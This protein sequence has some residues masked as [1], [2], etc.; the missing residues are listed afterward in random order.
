MISAAAA[1][2][3]SRRV[4]RT[5]DSSGAV[6]RSAS[7]FASSPPASAAT[8]SSWRRLSTYGVKSMASLWHHFGATAIVWW[9]IRVNLVRIARSSGGWPAIRF[10]AGWHTRKGESC[11]IEP[12][13]PHR[14]LD[15]RGVLGVVIVV[16]GGGR[17]GRTIAVPAWDTA[18]FP[19]VDAS[20]LTSDQGRVLEL[21][22]S[23]HEQDR[24]GTFYS[25]GIDEEWCADF[26]S[27]IM[28]EAG[29]PLSNP[30]SGSWRIPGVY[31]LQEYYQGI[32]AYA[33]NGS[34]YTP[35]NVGD[36]VIYDSS[37]WVGQHTNIVVA[38]DGNSAVT[39]GGNE[40]G[41]V[42]VHDLDWQSD[43]ASW[44]SENFTPPDRC[45]SESRR[46]T[47]PTHVPRRLRR[48]AACSC[49]FARSPAHL[50]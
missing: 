42:R 34:G 39:V 13:T 48:C 1:D 46:T 40:F 33:E 24:P 26:V 50:S 41:K 8:A 23:E 21:L 7:A 44:D 22:Q 17:R 37:R 4:S 38:V 18:E 9:H 11:R 2:N 20:A 35:P 27:W 14:A 45:S 29:R 43:S 30:N 25:D 12:P 19:A 5:A 36:V 49:R 10:A 3:A 47:A 16:G 15:C 31:T 6:K 28:R 32:G